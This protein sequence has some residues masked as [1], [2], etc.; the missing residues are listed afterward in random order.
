MNYYF[1]Y[2]FCLLNIGLGLI[3]FGFFLVF[4]FLNFLIFRFC[5]HFLEY[6]SLLIFQC[7][8]LF[9]N[10]AQSC[11]RTSARPKCVPPIPD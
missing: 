3:L 10:K 11:T 5:L 6:S 7:F 9:V 2:L 8:Q 4:I 1:S